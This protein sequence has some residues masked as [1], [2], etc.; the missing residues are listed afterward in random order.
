MWSY[1]DR[2]L[3]SETLQVLNCVLSNCVS[4]P[5]CWVFKSWNTVQSC[6]FCSVAQAGFYIE[7]ERS[8]FRLLFR[9]M[10]SKY[11][12]K[13]VFCMSLKR[14]WI[15]SR[16]T[17][18]MNLADDDVRLAGERV[19]DPTETTHAGP[20]DAL[21]HRG[22][23]SWAGE[24]RLCGSAHGLHRPAVL[25]RG[26]EERRPRSHW[27]HRPKTLPIACQLLVFVAIA[28]K[29][30]FWE[31][32]V[33]CLLPSVC[34]FHANPG[35]HFFIAYSKRPYQLRTCCFGREIL[36]LVI[37][38]S[39]TINFISPRAGRFVTILKRRCWRSHK[40]LKHFECGTEKK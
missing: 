26:L 40:Y 7:G 12:M 13:H 31:E 1:K 15:I 32:L 10:L 38:P 30:A 22:A 39:I 20:P 6:F 11:C 37:S 3:F 33:T 17:V 5:L 28:I 8:F 19:D 4:L 24:S 21:R 14:L 35:P 34:Y 23:D 36:W 9:F 25:P 2:M 16:E 27:S 29:S 18:P